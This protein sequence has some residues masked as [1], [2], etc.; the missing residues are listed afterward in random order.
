MSIRKRLAQWLHPEAGAATTPARR[1]EPR[2]SYDAISL[3]DPKGLD[4]WMRSGGGATSS[5][6]LVSP[7]AAMSVAAV[8]ACVNA[9]STGIGGLPID[10]IR[11]RAGARELVHDHP[12]ALQLTRKRNGGLRPAEFRQM[13]TAHVLLTGNGYARIVRRGGRVIA[14]LPMDPNRVE[15]EQRPDLSLLYRYTTL[16]G[17]YVELSERDVFHLRGYTFDGVRGVSV[18]RYAREAIGMGLQIERHGG[19]MFR[20]GARPSGVLQGPNTLSDA[21]YN[22]LEESL[23]EHEGVENAGRTLILEEGLQFQAVTMS[24]Q[25]IQFVQSAQLTRETIYI[26]FRMPPHVVGDT[27]KQTSFGAGL[28]N[29]SISYV[30]HT[31]GP[32]IVAWEEAVNELVAEADVV[33]RMNVNALL[34]GDSGARASY[35]TQMLQWGVLSPDEVRASEDMSPRPDGAGGRYYEAPNTAGTPAGATPATEEPAAPGEPDDQPE[36]LAA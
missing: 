29:Q 14:L 2:L 8:Y 7:E 21:A 36:G 3:T 13:L 27:T 17:R 18:I 9:I 16:D 11:S 4:D 19:A 32:W 25:D 30:T 26:Y 23:G 1:I 12:V 33:T 35:Y 20:Q 22:R 24:A 6:A 5:G 15:I 31:L 28:Q 34:R 10:M